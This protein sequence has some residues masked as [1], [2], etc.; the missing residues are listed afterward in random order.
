[1]KEKQQ[2]VVCQ[3]PTQGKQPTRID[4]W[5]YDLI[6]IK[7]LEILPEKGEGVLFKDLSKLVKARLSEYEQSRLGSVSWYTTTVKLDLEVRGEIRKIPKTKPQ[8]L[9]KVS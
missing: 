6:R 2:K 4:R 8:R 1:M 5:K 9:L 7:V 3:T